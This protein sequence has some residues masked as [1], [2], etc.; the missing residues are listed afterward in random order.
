[1]LFFR[2]AEG[3]LC[4]CGS[5]LG[6]KRRNGKSSVSRWENLRQNQSRIIFMICFDPPLLS[7][8]YLSLSHAHSLSQKSQLVLWLVGWLVDATKLGL[9][10][11]ARE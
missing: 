8:A 7:V 11:S 6:V 1:M 4:V 2:V 5:G 9:S 10:A 3:G